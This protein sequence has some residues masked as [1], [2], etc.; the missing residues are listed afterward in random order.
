[1]RALKIAAASPLGFIATSGA[2]L[3]YSSPSWHRSDC[4]GE[5]CLGNYVVS[6]WWCRFGSRFSAASLWVSVLV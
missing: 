5:E 4:S 2:I 3:L 6:V 1:V